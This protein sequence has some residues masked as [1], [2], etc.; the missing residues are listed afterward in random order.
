MSDVEGN[1]LRQANRLA[2]RYLSEAK[3]NTSNPSAFYESLELALHNYLKANLNIETSEMEK[4]LI[5]TMLSERRVD[6]QT[7]DSFI[8]ILKSCEFARYASSSANSV[9]KDYQKAVD[10]ISNI[11]KQIQ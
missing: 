9:E 4:G 1:K 3:K 2:R 7:I 6:N 5:S 11:D 10:V 8:N